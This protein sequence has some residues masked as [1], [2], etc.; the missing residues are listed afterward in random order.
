MAALSSGPMIYAEEHRIFQESLRKLIETEFLPHVDSWEEN[1]S[2]P[3]SVFEALGRAGFLGIL[4]DEKWGGSAGDYTMAAAWCEEWGRLPAVGLTTG[5]NMH[6]LVIMPTVQRFANEATKEKWLKDGVLGK[7]IGAY[8]FTEPGAGSDLTEVR[9]SAKKDGDGWIL[10]GSKIFITNGERA[11]F[12]LVLAKTDTSK[13]YDGFT[14]FIVDTA[15]PG[16]S[17]ARTLS[18]L[19]WH[20]SDTAEL[21]FTDL[22][23]PAEAVL[24]QV[25]RGW[26]QAMESLQWERLML[27]LG[28]LGGASTC[29][30]GT[31]RYVN[32]RKVFGRPVSAYDNTRD[33]LAS[34]ASR[35]EAAR[36][37]CHRCVKQLQAGERCRK[38]TSLCKIYTC[39]LAIEVADRCL[40][41][42]GGYGYT[43]EFRPERWLRDLRLNTI[44]G[45]TSEIM[46]RIAVKELEGQG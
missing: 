22:R 19:G 27:S 21:V 28:A 5:V 35:L 13:G 24:G 46:A 34:L 45:G 43:T 16:F 37:Y 18:K 15:L 23:L 31:V 44:G 26:H 29:L 11:D 25:G 14:T 39:E 17:V 40:Q 30:E 2:F 7:A 10:N 32:D 6:S 41:L 36:A 8:A 4:I 1:R 3:D 38:E 12:V 42:H 9:T 20:S 33:V